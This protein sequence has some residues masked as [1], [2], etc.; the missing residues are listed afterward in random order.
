MMVWNFGKRLAA[1]HSRF[2]YPWNCSGEG[3]QNERGLHESL[4]TRAFVG[5]TFNL[6][7]TQT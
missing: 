2:D 7:L 6:S 5:L 1:R 4:T 3:L